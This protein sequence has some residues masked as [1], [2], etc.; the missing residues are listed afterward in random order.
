MGKGG[1]VRPRS[2]GPPAGDKFDLAN[3]TVLDGEVYDLRSFVDAHPG[4][5]MAL[6]FAGG[7]DLS[8][9]WPALHAFVEPRAARGRLASMRVS[10]AATR[11]AVLAAVVP[12]PYVAGEGAAA[13][14]ARSARE[15]RA[16]AD[17]A[18]P[19]PEPPSELL[20][21]ADLGAELGARAR[22][23]FRLRRRAAGGGGSLAASTKAPRAAVTR[24]VLVLA[25]VEI[26]RRFRSD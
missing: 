6:K 22:W 13:T 14:L 26:N 21:G 23:H 4:G 8:R 16:F 15:A 18:E 17:L 12:D 10:D 9:T 24:G 2:A 19:G 5:A 7:R 25:G 1:D 3:Y 11:A 20:A